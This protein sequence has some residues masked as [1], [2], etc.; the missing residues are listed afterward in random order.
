MS[1]AD[2]DEDEMSGPLSPRGLVGAR[3]KLAYDMLRLVARDFPRDAAAHEHHILQR[4]TN[5][6]YLLRALFEGKP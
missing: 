2:D 3:A 5:A 4:A 1:F 6:A